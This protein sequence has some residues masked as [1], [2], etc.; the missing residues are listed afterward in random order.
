M[1]SQPLVPPPEFDPERPSPRDL[2]WAYRHGVFPMGDPRE[3]GLD[4]FAPDPRGVIPLDQFHV[5]RNLAKEV[6]RA[7]LVIRSDT[8]FEQVM[9]RCATDRSWFNVS[10]ITPELL[11]AYVALHRMGHAH[12]IEAWLPS[13]NGEQ[14]VGGLYG[15]HIGAAFFGESMFSDPD[16][17][18]SNSSKVCLV[19]L[20][21]WLRH[22]G[23]ALL[24]TQFRNP[25]LAQ[26]G[27]IE[28][29]RKRYLQQLEAAVQS[30]AS[31][32]EFRELS[33]DADRD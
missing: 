8:A 9:R 30:D 25:H 32:G 23:F 16:Q 1:S 33:S 4:W 27:C 5:P 21:R 31:W 20:V 15:V 10:W 13:P 3:G 7:R 11:D 26:F 28:I 18:G 17:G 19:H 12:S 24:D 2:L 22:R 14:L 29:P 6:R